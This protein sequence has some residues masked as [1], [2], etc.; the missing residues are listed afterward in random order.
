MLVCIGRARDGGSWPGNT[1]DTALIRQVKDDMRDWTLSKIVWVGDRGFASADNRRYLR[2]GDHHCIIGERLRSGS[3]E[4]KAALSRQGRYQD[5]AGNLKVKEVRIG[6][7]DRFVICFN[8]EGTERNAAIRRRLIAQ[9]EEVIAG[10]D[11]LS[12]T[13]RAELRGV[14]ST[15]PG[16]NRYLRT[17]PNGLL[18]I[19]AAKVKAETTWTASTCCAAPTPSCR[20]RT[21]P[22]VTSNCWRSSGAGA[23]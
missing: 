10:T 19:D 5:V 23:T 2:Q 21:S 17:T 3:A 18:R 8:P 6:E 1:T 11:A 13:K 14:I 20:P 22:S 15:E 4:A 9:L 7:A 12:A 16:L